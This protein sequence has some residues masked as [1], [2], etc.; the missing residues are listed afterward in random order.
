MLLMAPWL[1]VAP[2]PPYNMATLVPCQVP[3]V[4]TPELLMSKLDVSTTN[5]ED[6][7]PM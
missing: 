6:P 5:P 4:I 2:V 7:P 1:V 3:E